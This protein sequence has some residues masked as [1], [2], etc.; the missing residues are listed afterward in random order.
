M[1][2]Y[3]LGINVKTKLIDESQFFS[4][5]TFNSISYCF[6]QIYHVKFKFTYY[7]T[8]FELSSFSYEERLFCIRL[9]AVIMVISYS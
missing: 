9:F 6:F 8:V 4:P 2:V 7:V 3:G 1:H 5:L